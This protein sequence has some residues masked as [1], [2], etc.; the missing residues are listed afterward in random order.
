MAVAAD[1]ARVIDALR[2]P[3]PAYMAYVQH[4]RVSGMTNVDHEGRI[5]VRTSDRTIVHGNSSVH[6]TVRGATFEPKCYRATD[7]R[8]VEQGGHRTL[9]F[10]LQP[11][12]GGADDSPFTVLYADAATM[13]PVRA[14]GNHYNDHAR[15]VLEQTFMQA[16][17]YTVPA[18]LTV[19]VDGD[20]L[21]FWLHVHVDEHYR[22]YRFSTTDPGA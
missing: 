20:G 8:T 4:D 6:T 15:V 7:E 2:R 10:D 13:L 17:G 22:D 11:T 18:S 5:V 1:Y 16:Q 21:V 14:T 9:A 12:C 19:G 3:L